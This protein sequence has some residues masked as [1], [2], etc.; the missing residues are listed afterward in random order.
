MEIIS[1]KSVVEQTLRRDVVQEHLERLLPKREFLTAKELVKSGI[2]GS[3]SSV[4]YEVRKN[5]LKVAWISTRRYVI[6]RE[7]LID[8]IMRKT[9]QK[10]EG[11]KNGQANSQD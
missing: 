7:S 3:K 6:I 1:Q 4:A 5:N 11:D 10:I 8:H 9:Q 2:F